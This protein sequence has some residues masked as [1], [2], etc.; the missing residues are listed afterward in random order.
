MASNARTEGSG[1]NARD[2]ENLLSYRLL[3]VANLLSRSQLM[4]FGPM[5]AISL[6]EWRTLAL[7]TSFGP[8]SVKSL[9]RYANLDLGQTSRL[10]SRMCDIGLIEKQRGDD[11]RSVILSVTASGRALHRRLWRVAMRCNNGFLNSLSSSSRRG[12]LEALDTLTAAAKATLKGRR[13]PG[14]ARGG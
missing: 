12:L 1:R 6:A 3:V 7:V 14:F 2:I 11:A 5:S 13:C 8:L 4:R 9:A 10:V